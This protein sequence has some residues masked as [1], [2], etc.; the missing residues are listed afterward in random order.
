MLKALA[1]GSCFLHFSW[2]NIHRVLCTTIHDFAFSFFILVPGNSYG[3]FSSL[4]WAPFCPVDCLVWNLDAWI[5]VLDEYFDW[6]F[7]CTHTPVTPLEK[8][9][10]PITK[11]KLSCSTKRRIR[12]IKSWSLFYEIPGILFNK[13]CNHVNWRTL[14]QNCL[15]DYYYSDV[16][17]HQI[18]AQ[19]WWN[20]TMTLFSIA[21][22]LCAVTGIDSV[23]LDRKSVV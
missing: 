17:R 3:I 18:C 15:F 7:L 8:Y 11:R 21:I 1:S 5:V 23:A 13:N 22:S 2:S 19:I 14:K 9:A 16:H 12:G 6:P 20:R 4:L 10:Y